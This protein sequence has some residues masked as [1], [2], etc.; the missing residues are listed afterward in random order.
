MWSDEE[1]ALLRKMAL[2][3]ATARQIADALPT[4]RTR[5]AVLGAC[6][7]FGVQLKSGHGGRAPVIKTP[8]EPRPKPEPKPKPDVAKASLEPKPIGGARI[9]MAA[10][11][12]ECRAVPL[13]EIREGQCK[14]AVNNAE[15]GEVHLFCGN[16]TDDILHPYCRPHARRARGS[17]TIPERMASKM[18]ERAR[19]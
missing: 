7:R 17:G 12:F 18:P 6:H 10:T 5:S 1:I 13:A 3:G 2:E 14:W 11:L 19:L 9:T 8:R 4:E 15:P 16:A